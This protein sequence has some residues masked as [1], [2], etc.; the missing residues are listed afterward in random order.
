MNDK[1]EGGCA[2]ALAGFVVTAGDVESVVGVLITL[3]TF[4]WW[5]RLW[6]R[7][8]RRPGRRERWWEGK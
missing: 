4:L 3:M 5:V 8:M 2:T 6:I 7:A 1:V